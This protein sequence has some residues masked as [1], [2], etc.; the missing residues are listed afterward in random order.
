VKLGYEPTRPCSDRR[1]AGR[2]RAQVL[3]DVAPTA[4]TQQGT[5]KLE[6]TW[7]AVLPALGSMAIQAIYTG[8]EVGG[9]PGTGGRGHG[10]FHCDGC[11][12]QG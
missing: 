9:L 11:V 3:P 6:R 1:G 12:T 7:N 10:S 8:P 5:D 2:V 4:R